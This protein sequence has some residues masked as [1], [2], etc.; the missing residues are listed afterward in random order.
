[1]L[2]LFGA[3]PPQATQTLPR[4]SLCLHA[5]AETVSASG[6]FPLPLLSL[7][8]PGTSTRSAASGSEA[9]AT[10]AAAT[11]AAAECAGGRGVDGGAAA[12]RWKLIIIKKMSK[13]FPLWRAA[14]R[15]AKVDNETSK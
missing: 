1:M 13:E 10:V 15:R 7:S 6:D 2:A 4:L 3:P 5:C 8:S 11:T 9:A 14:A 12:G